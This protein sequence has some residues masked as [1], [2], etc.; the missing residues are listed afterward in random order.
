MKKRIVRISAKPIAL[1]V[2]VVAFLTSLISTIPLY[3]QLIKIAETD[4]LYEAVGYSFLRI[5]FAPFL[6][7]IGGYLFTFVIVALYN[8]LAKYSGGIS[9]EFAD[10]AA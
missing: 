3:V 1:F 4:I 7:L 8:F 5:L 2:G 10:D 9:V 6:F